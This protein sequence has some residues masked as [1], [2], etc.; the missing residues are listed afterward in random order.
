MLSTLQEE[1]PETPACIVI[2]ASEVWELAE[3]EGLVDEP[4]LW[5]IVR[6]QSIKRENARLQRAQLKADG[7]PRDEWPDDVKTGRDTRITET[8]TYST[9]DSKQQPNTLQNLLRAALNEKNT[10]SADT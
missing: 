7:I 6:E 10:D 8:E 1:Q 3:N 4:G 9:S 2:P 5:D